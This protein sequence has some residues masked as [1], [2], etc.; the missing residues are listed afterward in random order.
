MMA[1]GVIV[2]YT[3]LDEPNGWLRCDGRAVSR[4]RFNRLFEM[5]NIRYGA[6]DGSTTFNLPDFRGKTFIA[7]NDATLPNGQSA[8]VNL[9]ERTYIE[10]DGEERHI[11]TISEL[12]V[13]NHTGITDDG[14]NLGGDPGGTG[15]TGGGGTHTHTIS[16][17]NTG[18]NIPHNNL[19]PYLATHFL[20]KY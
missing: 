18:D 1:V 20:I 7:T 16:V 8:D 13:H 3:G 5:I 6:G 12:P 14:P 9:S 19:Q 2:P 10:V 11:L 15:G 17:D 4:T